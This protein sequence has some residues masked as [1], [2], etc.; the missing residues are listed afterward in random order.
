MTAQ[1]ERVCFQDGLI[2][3]GR[4]E[5]PTDPSIRRGPNDNT[6][7]NQVFCGSCGVKVRS[8]PGVD[9]KNDPR[10]RAEHEALYDH[11]DGLTSKWFTPAAHLRVYACRCN[12]RIVMGARDLDVN[13]PDAWACGG[14]SPPVQ[15]GSEGR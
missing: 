3:S 6:P 4:F 14:H 2:V 11:Q 13:G 1:R 12:S 8:W 9:L 15:S 5:I 10:N 7:C